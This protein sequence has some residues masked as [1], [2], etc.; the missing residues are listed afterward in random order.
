MTATDVIDEMALTPDDEAGI[1]SLLA[2]AFA[3]YGAEFGGRSYFI[4][5]PHR[6][7]IHRGNGRILAHLSLFFRTIRHGDRLAAAVG[8]GDVAVDSAHRGQGLAAGLVA[9]AIGQARLARAE[10]IYLHGSEK[11]YRSAGFRSV[12]N[13]IRAVDMKNCKTV[14][15]HYGA[16]HDLMVLE[17]AD[18]TWDDG[19]ETDLLGHLV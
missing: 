12:S 9:D 10:L 8:I 1:A 19:A 18:W 16:N 15:I 17:L 3:P 2:E 7:L 13:P 11:I 6:R 5:R 14:A 4:Q